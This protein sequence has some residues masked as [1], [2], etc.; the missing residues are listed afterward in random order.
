MIK[1]YGITNCTTVQK[2]RKWLEANQ[3]EYEFHDYKKLGIDRENLQ[4]WCQKFGWE[5]VLNR[6]GMMWRK[7]DEKNKNKVV[8]TDSAI[9]FMLEIPTSIKRPV[10]ES[11]G[12]LLIGFDEAEYEEAL[13]Q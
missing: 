11:N 12:K 10:I 9:E 5:T 8:D 3:L 4:T 1:V 13:L 6:K 2:A 7:A